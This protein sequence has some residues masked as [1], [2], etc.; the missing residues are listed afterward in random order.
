MPWVAGVSLLTEGF[1]F[2][3]YFFILLE[4]V[5]G[6]P[7]ASMHFNKHILFLVFKR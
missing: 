4:V 2:S 5:N 1:L 7:P 3:A 6:K